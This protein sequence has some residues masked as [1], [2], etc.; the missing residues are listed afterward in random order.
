MG[1]E[2]VKGDKTGVE[3]PHYTVILIADDGTPYKLTKEAWMKAGTRL[4]DAAGSGIVNQLREFGVYL[5]YIPPE[6]AVGIGE[7]CTVVNLQAILKNNVG[8]HGKPTPPKEKG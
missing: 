8:S 4:P 7:V 3:D 6:I 2:K 1:D 5:S